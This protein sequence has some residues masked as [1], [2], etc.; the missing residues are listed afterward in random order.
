MLLKRYYLDELK[1]RIR[2]T[3]DAVFEAAGIKKEALLTDEGLMDRLWTFYQKNVEEYG[4]DEDFSY[5][6]ALKEVL[7]IEL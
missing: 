6:D 3:D 2:E 4:C 5:G 7:N 1:D